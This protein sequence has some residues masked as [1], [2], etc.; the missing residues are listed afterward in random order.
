[1]TLAATPPIE[2]VAL[3]ATLPIEMVTLPNE[4][5]ALPSRNN[6]KNINETD[7]STPK[8]SKKLKIDN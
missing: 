8:C 5:L 2:T 1:M 7:F 3:A 6:S 4:M